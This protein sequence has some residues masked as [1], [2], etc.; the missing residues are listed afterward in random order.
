ML[1]PNLLLLKDP[2]ARLKCKPEEICIASTASYANCI[3]IADISIFS[4][5]HFINKRHTVINKDY[6]SHH[7][8]TCHTYKQTQF[9]DPCTTLRCK[10]EEICI[11]VDFESSECIKINDITISGDNSYYLRRRRRILFEK[12]PRR[13]FASHVTHKFESPCLDVCRHGECE[14]LNMTSHQ[15]H[16]ISVG[17]S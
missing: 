7:E 13:V 17:F 9:T 2:C 5:S 3:P 12:A 1:L 16:C 11:V 8:G 14:I 10:K 4:D 6:D 15:C